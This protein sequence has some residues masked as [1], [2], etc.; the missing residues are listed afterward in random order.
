MVG[1]A[2]VFG[3]SAVLMAQRWTTR[4]ADAAR[5]AAPV[6]EARPL[7]VGTIVVAAK[8][9]RYGMELAASS[10]REVPWPE[11]TLPAGAYKT[12]AEVLA[13]NG[14]RVVLSAIDP[15]EP[16]L[17]PKITGPG[18]RS[19]LSALIDDG[20]GAVHRS[21]ERGRGCRG[22]SSPRRPRRR[23]PDPADPGRRR[24]DGPGQLR[25]PSRTWCCARCASAVGQTAD[26][27]AD[28][29]SVVTA[30]TLEVEFDRGSEDRARDLGRHPVADAAQGRRSRRRPGA[31]GL[32]R[33]DRTRAEGLGSEGGARHPR[34]GASRIFG[35]ER[36]DAGGDDDGLGSDVPSLAA[37]RRGAVSDDGE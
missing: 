18:Q 33:G 6:E 8:P 35:S 19:T 29:P 32:A 23:S 2:I 22:F 25:Q 1:L 4:Q 27:R 34:H 20:I 26:D 7:P 13:G 15:N 12:V 5:P 11:G 14:K 16:V 31:S 10:I 30:V 36:A 24:R 3:G 37:G 9:L 17:Q 28:K 21:G